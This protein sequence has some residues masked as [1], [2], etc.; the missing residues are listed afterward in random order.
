MRIVTLILAIVMLP[1]SL[2]ILINELTPYTLNIPIK[3]D[4]LLIAAILMIVLQLLN[5]VFLMMNNAALRPMNIVLLIVFII[6]SSL[7][8][9]EF[10]LSIS[11]LDVLPLVMA[12]MMFV[13]S[14]YALH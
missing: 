11:F 6:P 12:I 4:L 1:L 8:F 3:I 2:I 10:F 7:Y 9:L 13:E 5:L 14:L